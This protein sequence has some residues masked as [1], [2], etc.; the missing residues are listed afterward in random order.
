MRE[1]ISHDIG[2]M[3]IIVGQLDFKIVTRKG[4]VDQGK[5]VVRIVLAASFLETKTFLVELLRCFRFST[6]K[7]ASHFQ[8]CHMKLLL[9]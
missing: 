3:V 4:Q 1:T 7:Q 6:R 5:L 9:S 2:T 8:T